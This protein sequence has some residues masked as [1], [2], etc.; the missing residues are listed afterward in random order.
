M[1]ENNNKSLKGL[2]LEERVTRDEG[3]ASYCQKEAER[4]RDQNYD[5]YLS[6]YASRQAFREIALDPFHAMVEAEEPMGSENYIHANTGLNKLIMKTKGSNRVRVGDELELLFNSEKI[7]FFD[8][9]TGE[10]IDSKS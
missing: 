9:E 10:R 3:N 5:G 8:K 6:D 4:A 1:K 7:H 2:S